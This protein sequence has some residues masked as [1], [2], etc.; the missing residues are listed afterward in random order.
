MR[1]ECTFV[2]MVRCGRNRDGR[3]PAEPGARDA[4]DGTVAE[5]TQQ[6]AQA[7]GSFPGGDEDARAYVQTYLL[8][9]PT[10]RNRPGRGTRVR[11]PVGRGR[12]PRFLPVVRWV[13]SNRN[14][15]RM[16]RP[17]CRGGP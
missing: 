15:N 6:L 14:R 17:I 3:Y 4:R 8:K 1:E 9:A 12:Y 7:R 10:N 5:T 11:G 2:W 13:L 16:D